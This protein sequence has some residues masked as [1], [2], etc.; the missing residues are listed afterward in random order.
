M[1]DVMEENTVI[2]V[3]KK[4][5]NDITRTSVTNVRESKV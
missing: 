2:A 3:L 4:I 1:W 5:G